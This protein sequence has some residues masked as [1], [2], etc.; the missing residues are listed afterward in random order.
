VFLRP[1]PKMKRKTDWSFLHAAFLYLVVYTRVLHIEQIVN[2]DDDSKQLTK[3]EES[4]Q[5]CLK[6]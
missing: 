3:H 2:D 6:K 4:Q 1:K 5:I